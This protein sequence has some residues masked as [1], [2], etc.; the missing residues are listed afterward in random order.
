VDGRTLLAALLVLA[1]TLAVFRR[2]QDHEFLNYDDDEYVLENE[3]VLDGLSVASVGRAF[4]SFHANNWHPLTWISHMADVS[5]FGLDAGKHHRTSAGL[6]ALAAALLCLALTALTG[7]HGASL[8]V[9]LLFALH[10]LRAESVAWVAERKDVLAG[11]FFAATLL[12]HACC[13]RRPGTWP[14][15]ARLGCL[16]LGLLS[17]PMLVTLPFLLLVLD[18]WPL[19]R[20]E[21]WGRLLREKA[22][23]FVL[24]GAC[25]LATVLAQGAGGALDPLADLGAGARVANALRTGAAYLGDLLWPTGLA[26]FYP[27]PAI[28]DGPGAAVWTSGVLLAALLLAASTAGAVLLRREMPWLLAGWL[29]YLGMLVP[30]AGLVQVG[31]QARADRYTYLPTIGVLVALVW[32]VR[33]LLEQRPPWRPAGPVLGAAAL[34]ALVPLTLRQVDTWRTT[35]TAM[36]HALRVTERNFVAHTNLA[37][38]LRA[39]G[40]LA[41]AR[42]HYEEA[43]AIRPGVA[44]SHYNLAVLLQL[45]GRFEEARAQLAVVVTLQPENVDARANLGLVLSHLDRDAGAVTHLGFAHRALPEDDPRRLAIGQALAWV[46][47]TSPID[48]LRDG[49]EAERLARACLEEG[50]SPLALETLAAALAEQERWEEALE[51]ERE[52]LELVPEEERGALEERLRGYEDGRPFRRE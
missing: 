17:K 3:L 29:W 33:A 19:A 37:E 14:R 22:L 25:A 20:P 16:A 35:E 52:A 8:L 9:A 43:L 10:P 36:E 40:D 27:H 30:V 18:R 49:E 41:G 28:L 38:V 13:V 48:V 11:V 15:A 2:T 5:L 12:A 50:R 24:A 7:A 51:A 26:F 39:R 42:E 21:G 32:S 46:L 44:A 45:E 1:A 23:L 31:F 34:V 6:H 4:T 47:A